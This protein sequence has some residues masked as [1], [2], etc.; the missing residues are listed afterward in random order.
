MSNERSSDSFLALKLEVDRLLEDCQNGRFADSKMRQKSLLIGAYTLSVYLLMIFAQLS[1][2]MYLSCSILLALGTTGIGINLMH[3]AAHG[4]YSRQPWVN[5]LLAT[6]MNV[7][8]A[9]INIWREKHNRRH[10]LH[11]NTKNQDPDLH[12]MFLVRM[13]PYMKKYS[14]HK[15][16]TIF[17][18]LTYPLLTIGWVLFYDFY[19]FYK[20]RLIYRGRGGRMLVELIVSKATYLIAMIYLPY[21]LYQDFA[22]VLIGFLVHHLAMGSLMSLIFEVNHITEGVSHRDD[23]KPAASA[24]W[25]W[26]VR[27]TS[28]YTVSNPLAAWYLGGLNYQI[29]HHLFPGICSIHYPVVC[30]TVKAHL[31]KNGLPYVSHGSYREALTEHLRFL[32]QVNSSSLELEH[33]A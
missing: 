32:S 23:L 10:H 22:L 31:E 29:E 2:I 13:N 7:I 28:N 1:P 9:D 33:A 4:A 20:F 18:V 6:S 14:V 16:W 25:Q 30:E 11:V 3:D 24:D 26:Q 19:H 15:G 27:T 21:V 17:V 5:R 12:Y 8:G